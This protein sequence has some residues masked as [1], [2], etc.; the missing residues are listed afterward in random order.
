MTGHPRMCTALILTLAL[1]LT[2]TLTLTLSLT[3]TLTL[4][5]TLRR[6][7]GGLVFLSF[8]FVRGVYWERTARFLFAN[9]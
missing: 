4:T 3:L 1:A 5:P 7:G 6:E 8:C 9:T 2:L